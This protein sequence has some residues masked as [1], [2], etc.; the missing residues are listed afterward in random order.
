MAAGLMAATSVTVAA[1]NGASP[2]AFQSQILMEYV[3]QVVNGIPTPAGSQQYGNLVSV[4]GADPSLAFT[5]YTE[6]TTT[7]VVAN[8]PLRI[9]DRT[10]TTT[11]YLAPAAG[12]FDDPD[13][14]RAG[15]PVQVST[16]RQQVIVDTSNG[17]FTVINLN[18]VTD[19]NP[20]E[21]RGAHMWLGIRGQT[22]RTRLT[23]QLN[24][25]NASPTGWFG[26][27]ATWN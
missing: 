10:G 13:S 14:F 18:T 15:L 27:Y 5:F 1:G 24:A 11:V 20:F 2:A 22:F 26:G 9:I 16:L 8:G 7:N 19:S 25:P 3:G 17:M 6:A 23:G 12:S 4:A 21:S